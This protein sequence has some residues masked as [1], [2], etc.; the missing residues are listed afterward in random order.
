MTAPLPTAW[1]SPMAGLFNAAVRLL[2]RLLAAHAVEL[3][4]EVL[5]AA[6]LNQRLKEHQ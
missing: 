5:I 3:E 6:E 1:T 4:A 2:N